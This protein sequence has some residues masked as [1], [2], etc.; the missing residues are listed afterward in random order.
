MANRECPE[1]IL[2]QVGQKYF[3][4]MFDKV[5]KEN[6]RRKLSASFY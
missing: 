2:G 4:K 5:G 6:V 1:M 3:K